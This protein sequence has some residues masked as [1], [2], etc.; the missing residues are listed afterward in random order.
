V[1]VLAVDGNSLAHR[2]WHA[3]A[4]RDGGEPLSHAGE[5]V[6]AVHGFFSMLAALVKLHHP[7]HVVVG[8]DSRHNERKLR[9][10]SYKGTRTSADPDLYRQMQRT[11]EL[12]SAA[13]F[14]THT[15]HGW[16]ADDVIGSTAALTE[17]AGGRCVI[18]TSD[19]D[20]FQLVSEHTVVWR[21][22][23]GV[24]N[25]EEVN[26]AWL[27]K[28]Y[29]VSG[30]GYLELAA[31]RGDSSD[32]LPGVA[33]VGEKTAIAICALGPVLQTLD[34]VKNEDPV[35]LTTLKSAAR[36]LLAGEEALMHNME[37][38]RIR[39]DLDIQLS[40]GSL[41]QLTT[42]N[43]LRELTSAGVPSAGSQLARALSVAQSHF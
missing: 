10:S 38:M 16:E 39:R 24:K 15:A 4:P 13:G 1:K 36:K 6:F 19:R 22:A 35:V 33:G 43:V 9:D 14:L 17:V 3:F 23:N 12:L 31:M 41:A 8:F 42:A 25:A 27:H 7:T 40:D 37:M 28:K 29:G 2:A 11:E 30:P 18:A 5:P 34:A 32:N 26:E 20:S 21:I